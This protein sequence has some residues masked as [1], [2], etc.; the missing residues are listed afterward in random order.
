MRHLFVILGLLALLSGAARADGAAMRSVISAQTEA[1][2]ADDV[3][4]AFSHA[5]PG[6]KDMF[7]TPE[8]FGRMV[9]QGYPMVWRPAELRFLA[10]ETVAG[11]LWQGVLIRDHAGRLHVLDYQ[12]IEGPDGWK[13][14]AVRLRKPPAGAV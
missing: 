7:D 2:L 6:I 14:N 5:S 1:F 10:T 11:Q 9:R 4:T 12:M 13:I 8:N 3:T